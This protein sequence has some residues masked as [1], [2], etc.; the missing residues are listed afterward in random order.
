M[1][2]FFSMESECPGMGNVQVLGDG[3]GA[4]DASSPHH[5]SCQYHGVKMY[6][7]PYIFYRLPGG[8]RARRGRM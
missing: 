2:L 3:H 8:G 1:T 4:L 6:G 5:R 7:P